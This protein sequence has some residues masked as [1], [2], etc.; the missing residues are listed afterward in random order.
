MERILEFEKFRNIGLNQR[1]RLVLNNTLDKS[2]MGN[3]VILI[4]ANN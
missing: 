1:E 2:S 4:G 3:L